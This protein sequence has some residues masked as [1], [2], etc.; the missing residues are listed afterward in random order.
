MEPCV[1][2][3]LYLCVSLRRPS[4]PV[5]NVILANVYAIPSCNWFLCNSEIIKFVIIHFQ[6][7]MTISEGE[8]SPHGRMFLIDKYLSNCTK[9]LIECSLVQLDYFFRRPTITIV[10][11]LFLT[12][13]ALYNRLYICTVKSSTDATTIR[14]CWTI[15]SSSDDCWTCIVWVVICDSLTSSRVDWNWFA[16]LG[17]CWWWSALRLLIPLV[18]ER[19]RIWYP[20]SPK[21]V[22]LITNI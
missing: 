13:L 16:C 5:S 15:Q 17:Q 14:N 8:G 19:E 2:L 7:D 10:Y 21:P 20:L 22:L 9:L 12:S 6:Y 18:N 4:L 1:A 3:A 11:S